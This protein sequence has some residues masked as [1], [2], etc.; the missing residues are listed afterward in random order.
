MNQKD[1]KRRHHGKKQKSYEHRDRFFVVRSKPGTQPV[2]F[3][4]SKPSVDYDPEKIAL[5]AEKKA[6]KD[7]FGKFVV[8]TFKNVVW[9]MPEL[10]ELQVAFKSGKVNFWNLGKCVNGQWYN[11]FLRDQDRNKSL[12]KDVVESKAG[13][14]VLV[15][16]EFC[17]RL[18]KK[19][20]EF[21]QYANIWFSGSSKEEPDW[22]IER[23]L[24]KS[25]ENCADQLKLCWSSIWKHQNLV[26]G[27]HVLFQNLIGNKGGFYA[28]VVYQLEEDAVMKIEN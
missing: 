13:Q 14:P 9:D 18:N 3:K 26:S 24:F 5:E 8:A 10:S 20:N 28:W 2:N 1:N 27:N 7:G 17:I 11:I 22:G 21:F 19:T 6:R 25:P 12:R 23:I 4:S 16:F 15:D